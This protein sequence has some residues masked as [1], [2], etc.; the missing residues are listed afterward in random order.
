MKA[1]TSP[2]KRRRYVFISLL[3]LVSLSCLLPLLVLARSGRN[4]WH[5]T[6]RLEQIWGLRGVTPGRLQKPRAMAI[7]DQD[8]LYIVDTT[9]RIQVFD[10]S[11]QFLH[12][13]QTPKFAN[14]K[15][16]GLSFSHD[17][18]LM[19]ADTHY[20]RVLF[21]EKDGTLVEE[22]TLG[23]EFGNEPGSFGLVTDVVEDSRGCLYVSEYGEYDRIQKFDK[24]GQFL[25]QWGGHGPE[26]GHFIR[27]QNMAVDENDH[28]WVVDACNDRVQVFDAT[29][30]SAKLVRIWGQRGSEV[31]RLRYPYDLSL[32]GRGHIY[33]CEFGNSR[34][35]KFTLDGESVG[36]W[37]KQGRSEGELFNPWGLVQDSRRRIHVLD[38]NNHRVQRIRL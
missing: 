28:V 36:V 10:R 16:T 19:V 31:G 25:F 8:R 18:L 13:W 3:A 24:N 35:Q 5:S 7:D 34:V 32:D 4:G 1:F 21:Y 14:G 15:P 33:I 20:F 27:P 6:G 37:G 11:G 22:R 30:S 23:G 29:G 17:G 9:A 2:S 26:P 38:S 12:G